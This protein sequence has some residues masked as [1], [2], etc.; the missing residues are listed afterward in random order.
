MRSD[1]VVEAITFV[2]LLI[3]QF[4]L[5]YSKLSDESTFFWITA[6]LR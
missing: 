4:V 2:L 6:S 5:F 1:I 3:K